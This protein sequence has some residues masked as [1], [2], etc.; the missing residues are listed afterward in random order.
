[1]KLIILLLIATLS[2]CGEAFIGDDIENTP[3]NNFKMLWKEHDLWFAHFE[4]KNIDWQAQY[5]KYYPQITSQTTADELWDIL[6]QMMSVLSDA[7]SQLKWRNHRYFNSADPGV[8]EAAKLFDLGVVSDYLTDKG[9]NTDKQFYY[10]KLSDNIGYIYITNFRGKYVEEIESIVS[11]FEDTDGLVVDIRSNTGG[12]DLQSHAIASVLTGKKQY[13]YSVQ[14]RNG[15][16]HDDFDK[17]TKW[18]TEPNERIQFTKPI[19]LITNRGSISAS[20]VFA[21]IVSELPH[22]TVL[23]DYSTGSFSDKSF[24]RFL[25]NGWEYTISH[26]RYLDTNGDNLEGIGVEPD[27]FMNAVP[28]DILNGE[29]KV[30]EKAIDLLQ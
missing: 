9:F 21:L 25:P 19:I 20:D 11:D 5:E 7:H 6:T 4:N 13:V 30:L 16:S 14:T 22:V 18:Y 28:E 2:A 12:N 24:S 29:D 10:G 8:F 1:M 23:G 26:Q 15:T 17:A 3:E 27:V